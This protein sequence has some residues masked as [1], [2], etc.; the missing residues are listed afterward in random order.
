MAEA[1]RET[2][3]TGIGIVS[4]LGEGADTHWQRLNRPPPT[5][6]SDAFAPYVVH[7]LAPIELDKQIP[8]K[9]DQRQMEPWQRIGTY[10][11]GLA[12]DSAGAKGNAELLA[13][14]DMIVAAGGGERDETVDATI[15]T[16]LRKAQNKGT[17]LNE[18]LMSDLR[19]TLFLAQL[20]NLL[21]GNI[22]IVHGVTGMSRTFMGEESAGVDAVR[23]ALARIQAGQ[24]DISLVGGSFNAE[25]KDVLLL[26]EA[27]GHALKAPFAPVFERAGRGG[28]AIGSLGAFLV[29]ES[30]D[31]A[32]ARNAKPLA[33]LSSVQSDRVRRQPGA[34][35]E[36]L[37]KM[38]SAI[39]PQVAPGQVA[40]ISGASGSQPATAD[41]HA[42]LSTI[43]DLPVRATGTYVGHGVEPQFVMNIAL[44]SVALGHEK[45]FAPASGS[46][47]A[48]NGP[49]TQVVV[50][51]VGHWRGEGM[52][53]VEAA[54]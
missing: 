25:R 8:K 53:L 26:F 51:G 24:S 12:L 34:V 5:P 31:S 45:L 1:P 33:R 42:W 15:L 17:F 52:A 29:L 43:P 36:S 32:T 9:G 30:R 54:R 27:G 48:M 4:C 18:R 44:A 47:A 19:P 41:E 6:E 13:R 23:I 35:T 11:A 49:L 40:V 3:I 22:S 38:W 20:S 7:R 14:M 37:T 39:A 16:D 28:M 2:W 46:E 21:A 10:A 50:T